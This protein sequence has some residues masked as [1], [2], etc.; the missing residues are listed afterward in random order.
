MLQQCKFKTRRKQK[1]NTKSTVYDEHLLPTPSSSSF[2]FTLNLSSIWPLKNEKKECTVRIIL[3]NESQKDKGIMYESI[4]YM[5]QMPF[6]TKIFYFEFNDL[7]GL[8]W[9]G[10][11]GGNAVARAFSCILRITLFSFS[12]PLHQ[13]PFYHHC[14]TAHRTLVHTEKYIVVCF[15]LKLE[16]LPAAVTPCYSMFKFFL[17]KHFVYE[18]VCVWG[19]CRPFKRQCN[20]DTIIYSLHFHSQLANVSNAITFINI[21]HFICSLYIYHVCD[22]GRPRI[23]YPFYSRYSWYSIK[24][25]V[26]GIFG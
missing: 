4:Q 18:C 19:L 25:S 1:K 6:L 8:V 7:F 12:R 11:V 23:F 13:K 2:V 14:I 20:W 17:S 3:E 21:F 15:R 22:Q 16:M 26:Y 10:S 24:L 5:A 9:F